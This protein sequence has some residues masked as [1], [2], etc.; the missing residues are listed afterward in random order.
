METCSSDET[1]V[2]WTVEDPW[3]EDPDGILRMATTPNE[4]HWTTTPPF[5]Q[6]FDIIEDHRY[7]HNGS[8]MYHPDDPCA[9]WPVKTH[10]REDEGY[11]LYYLTVANGI[12]M[13]ILPMAL[14]IFF[15]ILVRKYYSI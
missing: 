8:E 9:P 13:G 11:I 7:V 6:S 12:F 3:F 15:N 4:T 10:L 1:T 2:I 5:N 14:M